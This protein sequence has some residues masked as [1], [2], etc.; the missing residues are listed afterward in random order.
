MA[1]YQDAELVVALNESA[2]SDLEEALLIAALEDSKLYDLDAAIAASLQSAQRQENTP[3]RTPSEAALA[4]ALA[5]Q[6]AT[7]KPKNKK[8]VSGNNGAS[9]S[10]SRS[11]FT[12]KSYTLG[13]KS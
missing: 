3:N 2:Q 8:H 9:T 10:S 5:R 4:A 7:C 6:T 11:P 1:S 12:G 13:Q